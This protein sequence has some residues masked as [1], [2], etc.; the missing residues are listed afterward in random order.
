MLGW[1][2]TF[3]AKN[4]ALGNFIAKIKAFGGQIGNFINVIGKL[5]A[6]GDSN[7]AILK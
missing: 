1:I 5:D 7:G 2:R 4:T 3:P 6:C